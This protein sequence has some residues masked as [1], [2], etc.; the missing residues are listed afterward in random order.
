VAEVNSE[1]VLPL[2]V[3]LVA[4]VKEELLPR[5]IHCRHCGTDNEVAPHVVG[6][7]CKN[8]ANAIFAN[9]ALN[10]AGAWHVGR[11]PRIFMRIGHAV[12]VRD[13]ERITEAESSQA[14]RRGALMR[15]LLDQCGQDLIEYALLVSLVGLAAITGMRSV[16]SSVS[17][18]YSNIGTAFVAY[19][20]G[21]NS[22]SPGQSGSA[23]GQS[24]NTPG[25]SGNTP[26][27]SGSAP[28]GQSGGNPGH[29]H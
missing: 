12:H 21:A 28:P 14:R 17:A 10:E 18:A 13:Q 16:A 6:K 3:L 11:E 22:A 1:G 25:Q 23:P 9:C 27:Q 4:R 5:I 24:G 19:I 8:Y 29:G 26:G 2:P 15:A 20:N 7:R